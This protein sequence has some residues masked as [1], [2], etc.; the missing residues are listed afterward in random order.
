VL[1]FLN[2][3]GCSIGNQ[4]LLSLKTA[5]ILNN[6][7]VCIDLGKN[8]LKGIA[9]GRNVCEF[10]EHSPNLEELILSSNMLGKQGVRVIMHRLIS[11]DKTYRIR[12]LGLEQNECHWIDIGDNSQIQFNNKHNVI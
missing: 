11:L 7:L 10:M 5:L 6:S 4:G 2:L 9:A 8:L 3:N 1:N 12:K